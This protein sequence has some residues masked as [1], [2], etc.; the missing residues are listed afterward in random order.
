[1]SSTRNDKRRNGKAF[2]KDAALNGTAGHRAT[3]R[4]KP[5]ANTI[6]GHSVKKLMTRAAL[7]A[8]AA[9]MNTSDVLDTIIKD[10]KK[11][12]EHT[13][14]AQLRAERRATASRSTGK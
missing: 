5:S 3:G 2:G 4:T 7:M 12:R 9:L 10:V 13:H 8:H 11:S 1:M 14:R 6:G